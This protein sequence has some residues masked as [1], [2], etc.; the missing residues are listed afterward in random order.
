[1]LAQG[2]LLAEASNRLALCRLARA[3]RQAREARSSQPLA[4]RLTRFLGVRHQHHDALSDARA[5]GMVIVRP[6]DHTGIDLT[7]WLTPASSTGVVTPKPAALGPFKSQR[8][9]IMGASRHGPLA[10]WPAQ[11]GGRILASV[12]LTTSILVVSRDHS[13]GKYAA[14]LPEARPAQALRQAGSTNEIVTEEQIRAHFA[15]G[16]MG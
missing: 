15:A 7:G 1:M 10:Q 9:A 13:F 16:A 4:E 11:L 14:A 8:M 5:A 12:G 6:I 2:D 3:R